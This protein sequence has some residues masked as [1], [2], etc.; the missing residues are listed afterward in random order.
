MWQGMFLW[1]FG[2]SHVRLRDCRPQAKKENYMGE[3]T[4]PKLHLHPDPSAQWQ[5]RVARIF[6][7]TL[8]VAKS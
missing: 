5:I 6:N 7:G 4:S 2:C 3:S 8:E 1:L